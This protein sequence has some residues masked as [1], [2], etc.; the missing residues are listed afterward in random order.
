MVS[1]A[2]FIP[3]CYLLLYTVP[4]LSD[5]NVFEPVEDHSVWL[6]SNSCLYVNFQA[7][8]WNTTESIWDGYL[9]DL[10]VKPLMADLSN[11]ILCEGFQLT[12]LY[13]EVVSRLCWCWLFNAARD[14]HDFC[15]HSIGK[16]SAD[17]VLCSF[18]CS[19]SDEKR[20]VQN[21]WLLFL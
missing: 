15:T 17:K 8:I 16:S 19:V 1:L 9:F 20:C 4:C 3:Y 21:W 10:I 18:L 7:N 2:P 5:K 13:T 14:F 12:D 11:I 6:T